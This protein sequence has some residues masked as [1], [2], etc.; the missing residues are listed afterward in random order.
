MI[1]KNGM[2]VFS[3]NITCIDCLYVNYG[4]PMSQVQKALPQCQ[5]KIPSE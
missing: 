1:K 2:F 3:C 4:L 5:V